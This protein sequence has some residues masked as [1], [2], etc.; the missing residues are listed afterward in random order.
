VAEEA[1]ASVAL[2]EAANAKCHL[3]TVDAKLQQCQR[4]VDKRY[5]TN[6]SSPVWL[7]LEC[8]VLKLW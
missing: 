2:V 1:A 6:E 4:H 3:L 8:V 7:M 5:H